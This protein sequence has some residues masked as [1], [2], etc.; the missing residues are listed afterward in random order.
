MSE[1]KA[2]KVI[3][4]GE[5]IFGI[6]PVATADGDFYRVIHVLSGSFI[7]FANDVI[8]GECI[9]KEWVEE[10]EANSNRDWFTPKGTSRD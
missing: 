3:F 10:R 9:A 5:H 4:V 7:G 6:Q 2:S 8:D 1:P